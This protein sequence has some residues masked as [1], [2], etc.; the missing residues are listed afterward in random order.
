M[1]SVGLANPDEVRA[2][3][4]TVVTAKT[5][6]AGRYDA[7]ALMALGQCWKITE[8]G[9]IV[10]ALVTSE[11]DGA[12]WVLAAVGRA[13]H[14]LV[15]VMAAHLG[16]TAQGRYKAIGFRT[17]RPGLVKKAQRHGYTVEA[18]IMRKTL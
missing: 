9:R 6:P 12:L 3:L 4:R 17:A 7:D 11:E 13:E 16:E 10:A 5:D 1:V 15:D 2:L 8:A 14:D 18:Y